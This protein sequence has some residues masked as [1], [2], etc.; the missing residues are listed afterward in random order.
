MIVLKTDTKYFGEIEFDE[1]DIIR[2]ERGLLGFE[3]IKK[4]ILIDNP[5]TGGIFKWL[6]AADRPE[7]AFVV[8]NPYYICADYEFDIPN[9]TVNKL[10]IEKPEDIVVLTIVVVPEDISKMTTNLK[11]PLIINTR[12][13]KA[14]QL[15][16]EDDRYSL[17]HPVANS[18][19]DAG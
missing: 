4:Y 7:P 16:L 19:R 9:G 13:N 12:N 3:E 14:E 15:V 11:A 6:Q 8:M 5:E 18:M 17:K 1:K 2:F 10:G